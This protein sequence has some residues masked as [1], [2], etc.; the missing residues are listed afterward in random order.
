MASSVL[1]ALHERLQWPEP[2]HVFNPPGAGPAVYCKLARQKIERPLLRVVHTKQARVGLLTGNPTADN[3]DAPIAIVCEFSAAITADIL[4]KIRK[5]SWNF[6]HSPLLI[7]IEPHLIRVWSC[8]EKPDAQS[9]EFPADPILEEGDRVTTNIDA[10]I[11]SLHWI[12]LASGQFFAQRADRF[13]R[14]QR[15]DTTL[16][17]NLKYVRQR[18][19]ADLPEDIAHDLLARIIFIQ[20]L[21]QRTDSRGNAALSPRKLANLH[22]LGVLSRSYT[23]LAE[24]LR[25]KSDT[26]SLFHWLNERFNGDLFPSNYDHEKKL[27][28]KPHLD[29]LSDF[30]DG[31]LRMEDG[32]YLL[33]P[34]YSFDAIPLEFISS[35]YEE[36]VTKRNS[37]SEESGI[38]DHYTR[39]FLVDFMLDKVLPWSGEDYN[40]KILDPCCGSAVF[41]VKAFQRLVHRW[42]TT[43]AGREPSVAFLK[44]LL[45]E[46]L[47]GVDINPKAIRVASFSLYLAM[48]DEIDPRHY[49]SKEHCFPP[50]RQLTLRD[51]DFFSNTLKGICSKEDADTY[52]LIIGNT[53]WGEESLTDMAQMWAKE[54]EWKAAD[55][56]VGTLFLPKT[57]ALC[58]ENGCICMIQPAGSLLFNVSPTAVDF[59]RRL[60][61]N[62]KVDE[63]INLSDLRFLNLFPK[64]VGPAC[65][66]IMRPLP[67]SDEPI[68]YWSP[69][70]TQT[71]EDQYR[72]VI[73]AQDLNWVWPEEAANDPVVWPALMWG[74]RRDLGF[75]R[76]LRNESETLGSGINKGSWFFERGFQ[77]GTKNAREY[78][79]RIG[80]PVLENHT[81]W[82]QCSIVSNA[83][84]FPPNENPMFEKPRKLEVFKLPAT[85][86]KESWTVAA[87]KRFRSIF[88][89]PSKEHDTLLVSNSFLAIKSQSK[90]SLSAF[91]IALNSSFAV[92]YLF[93]TS[94]RL[95]SYRPALRNQD[96]EEMPLP[97]EELSVKQL[98]EIKEADIDAAAFDLY[99]LNS[100]ERILVNDF[101]DVTLRDAKDA[102]APPGRN[103]VLTCSDEYSEKLEIYSKWFIDVLQSGFGHDK[104]LCTSIFVPNDGKPLPFCLVGIHLEWP[105]RSLIRYERLSNRN[106]L[107]KLQELDMTQMGQDLKI[108]GLYYKRVSRIYQTITLQDG[109]RPRKIPTVFLVKPNQERYWTISMALRDADEVSMDIYQWSQSVVDDQEPISYE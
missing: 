14:N 49:W 13:D 86:L 109:R 83:S 26:F 16:L 108:E 29:L 4:S 94:G 97:K 36:F 88:V 89:T 42:R 47:F 64:A 24:I 11:D 32:Q 78:S 3:S 35:I 81:I 12:Q 39:P 52:D 75:I 72:V 54:N 23:E 41:L 8:Y 31:K 91:T 60:F 19:T 102:I 57:A 80:Y 27:I 30:V 106:L 44:K 22:Q 9:G 68:A 10:L 46:N 93:M 6:C 58:K 34:H 33:W 92:Y 59:R 38:G 45:E 15:A 37:E 85:V 76:R 71:S 43:N 73:E 100:V 98:K 77:R 99:Q 84:Q 17:N 48:C 1:M 20:F 107:D 61:Q 66:I 56:Q 70:K 74:G 50:L 101:L 40:I 7:T 104:Q 55:K 25:S 79:D 2:D 53:P 95:A 62:Y 82:N 69:K 5:L 87:G 105:N 65:I 21:F 28:K 67:P 96:L 90:E 18:V 63:I 103:P 51:T